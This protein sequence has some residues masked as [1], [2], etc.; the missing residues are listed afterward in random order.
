MKKTV[1]ITFA[2]ALVLVNLAAVFADR[3][4]GLFIPMFFRLVLVFGITLVATI[5][6]GAMSL[7][8]SA[9]QERPLSGHVSDT[10]GADRKQAPENGKKVQPASVPDELTPGNK[11]EETD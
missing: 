10:L 7:V 3:Q 1:W 8:K 4:L 9:E 5:F 2:A 11:T 6:A